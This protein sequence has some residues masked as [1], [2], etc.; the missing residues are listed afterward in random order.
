M[1]RARF[2]LRTAMIAIALSCRPALLLA[3]EPTTALDA[4]VQIQVLILLRQL[5]SEFG[6]AMIFVTHSIDEAVLMGDRIVILGGRP[7]RVHDIVEVGIGRH[8]HGPRVA[9]T[10]PREAVGAQRCFVR[11]LLDVLGDDDH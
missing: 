1:R 5:Q 6:T 9:G 3:D 10:R 11:R 7:S 8:D 4:T 2:T